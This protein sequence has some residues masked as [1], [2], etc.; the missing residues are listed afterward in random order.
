MPLDAGG[1]KKLLELFSQKY[2]SSPL[3][4]IYGGDDRIEGLTEKVNNQSVISV[5]DISIRVHDTP[6]H[7]TGHV[8]YEASSSSDDR[9]PHALFSGDTLFSGG[10]G[11]FFEGDGAQMLSAV[12]LISSL[13]L[14]THIYC[15]H[16]YTLSNLVFAQT[17][18]PS[19][20]HLQ[21]K[22]AMVKKLRSDALPTIPSTLEEELTFNPFMRLDSPEILSNLGLD[23]SSDF[24]LR[25]T[26][27]R[28]TKNNFRAQ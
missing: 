13:R 26:K 7:T 8:I 18:E 15:G 6:C 9:A 14:D 28:E 21:S 22:L 27:L 19:N 10:V 2:P 23:A 3:P 24:S 1:N 25:M 16:E 5:G 12:K 11:K 20:V 17:I 4:I